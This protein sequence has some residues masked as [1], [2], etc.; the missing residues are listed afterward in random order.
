M[1]IQQRPIELGVVANATNSTAANICFRLTRLH[2]DII[3]FFFSLLISK[4]GKVVGEVPPIRCDQ[5]QSVTF[6]VSITRYVDNHMSPP[7]P[8]R[9]SPSKETYG[10]GTLFRDFW[11]HILL[12]FLPFSASRRGCVFVCARCWWANE[13]RLCL[14][15]KSNA[16]YPSPPCPF[17]MR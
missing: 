10:V 2:T 9:P 1:C 4:L 11:I 6:L 5:V 12:L 3:T 13:P 16:R 15:T 7:A 17:T 14:P 8:V